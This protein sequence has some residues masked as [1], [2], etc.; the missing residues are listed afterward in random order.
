MKTYK[1]YIKI[2]SRQ[3]CLVLSLLFQMKTKK[4][5]LIKQKIK[6]YYLIHWV[7]P[8]FDELLKL[9]KMRSKSR[10]HDH[11]KVLLEEKFLIKVWYKFWP[12]LEIRKFVI[13][14]QIEY[15]TSWKKDWIFSLFYK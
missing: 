8:T 13:Q 9:I 5:E 12:W 10:I 1:R 11:F 15:L 14:N 7:I 3:K 4:I 6:D 2:C